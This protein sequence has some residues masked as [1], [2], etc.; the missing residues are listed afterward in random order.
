MNLEHALVDYLRT[1]EIT[2]KKQSRIGYE[3]IIKRFIQHIGDQQVDEVVRDDIIDYMLYLRSRNLTNT[4]ISHQ[5]I[6]I[7]SF[8]KFLANIRGSKLSFKPELIPIPFCDT[9]PPRR[10]NK[11][12]LEQMKQITV[13]KAKFSQERNKMI[14]FFLVSSGIRVS[15]LVNLKI[16]EMDFENRV[17]VIRSSKNNEPRQ[18]FWNLEAS[19][20]MSAYLQERD[21]IATDDNFIVN[22]R[23]GAATTR[24]V[25][26][27]IK[28]LREKAKIKQRITPHTFRHTFAMDGLDMNVNL[29]HIQKLLGHKNIQS[30]QKYLNVND[31]EIRKVY[32]ESY[33]S[34]QLTLV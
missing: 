6:I 10:A 29:R 26:R 33:D 4:T 3:S 13:G 19:L 28:D 23:G 11:A 2:H 14:V 12:Q 20:Q 18:I 25:Q 31:V 16:S 8:F 17:A 22:N 34:N 30:T 15:E 32:K 24:L 9:A 1:S 5:I 21:K 7:R 27:I